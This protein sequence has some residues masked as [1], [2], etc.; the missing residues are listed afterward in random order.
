MNLWTLAGWLVLS[1]LIVSGASAQTAAPAPTQIPWPPNVWDHSHPYHSDLVTP[2]V[3]ILVGPM[4]QGCQVQLH[5]VLVRKQ[6]PETGNVLGTAFGEAY[7]RGGL[8]YQGCADVTWAPTGA[9]V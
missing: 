2:D 7:C 6:D 8:H 1:T 4:S 3:H 5:G 9:T